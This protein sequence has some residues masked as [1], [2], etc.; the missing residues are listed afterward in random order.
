MVFN[1]SITFFFF[2][3]YLSLS[4]FAQVKQEWKVLM[5]TC[6]SSRIYACFRISPRIIT[7]L[8]ATEIRTPWR[9]W[10]HLKQHQTVATLSLKNT[11]PSLNCLP[12]ALP[13]NGVREDSSYGKG[14]NTLPYSKSPELLSL[15]A[16]AISIFFH[17][18]PAPSV[19]LLMGTGCFTFQV[20]A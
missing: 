4:C 17:G 19:Q 15:E 14:Q 13:S 9:N 2:Y 6:R 18:Q 20:L 3:A 8:Q 10:H 1:L 7:D 11:L 16:A 12:Q 5:Y